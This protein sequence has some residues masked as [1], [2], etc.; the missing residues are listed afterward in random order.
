MAAAKTGVGNRS[1][2][3]RRSLRWRE[4]RLPTDVQ[5][6]TAERSEE[7]RV[8]K[9]C[10]SLCDWSSD[11]CSSDLGG[12]EN[13]RWQPKWPAATIAAMA[14]KATPH[15]RAE[16]DSGEIGRASCRERV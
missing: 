1:G 3:R 14:G 8:G 16:E 4:K 11:V 15:R 13:W 5:K 2:P 12:G 7:R 6:K 10:R 9:E